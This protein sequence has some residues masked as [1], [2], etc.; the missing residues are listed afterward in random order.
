MVDV[1]NIDH[2]L[3]TFSTVVRGAYEASPIA[4]LIG[5]DSENLTARN[6][7]VYMNADITATRGFHVDDY[8]KKLKSFIY[9][10]DVETLDD[11]PYTYVKGS[12]VESPFRRINR[13]LSRYLPNRTEA[14][15]VPLE[16]IVPAIARK[17]T[18]VI[19]DQGG[20]HRGFPQARGHSRMLSV[21]NYK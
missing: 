2:L 16:S 5:S 3:P 15:I 13:T 9:L 1:F 7:N 11:G 18:L 12:H 21:M 8:R 10:T 19:S 6:L 4:E 14:P 17:G 20:F